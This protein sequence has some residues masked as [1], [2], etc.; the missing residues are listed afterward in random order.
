MVARHKRKAEEV[1]YGQSEYPDKAA[2]DSRI[3]AK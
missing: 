3:R 1:M 2:V